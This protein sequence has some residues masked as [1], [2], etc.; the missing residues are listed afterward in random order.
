MESEFRAIVP[1]CCRL[2]DEWPKYRD[3]VLAAA[4]ARSARS[5][6]MHTLL[7][8]TDDFSEGD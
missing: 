8:A 5:T 7:Q 2:R 3:H 6:D 4:S 1:E